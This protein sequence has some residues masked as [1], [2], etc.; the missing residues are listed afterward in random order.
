MYVQSFRNVKSAMQME[1]LA[2]LSQPHHRHC[3]NTIGLSE[4]SLCSATKTKNMVSKN[5]LNFFKTQYDYACSDDCR[6]S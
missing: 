3:M 1:I 5:N 2:T 6:H 4:Q